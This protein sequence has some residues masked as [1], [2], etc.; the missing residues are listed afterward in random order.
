MMQWFCEP[1]L[2][3]PRG[4]SV[5][6]SR[7]KPAAA[8]SRSRTATTAWSIAVDGGKRLQETVGTLIAD[9]AQPGNLAPLRIEEDNARRT[10]QR[11]ALEERAMHFAVR[12]DVGLQH[13]HP[14]QLAAHPRVREGEALHLLARHAPVGVEVQHHGPPGSLQLTVQF[15]ER[16]DARPAHRRHFRL[17][18]AHQSRE[19][20]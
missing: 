13:A 14:L 18:F 15:R 4:V 1:M 9:D 8:A 17:A 2:W 20:A 10:E 7:R 16:A 19:R 5:K 3:K 11:K 6:P 12:G